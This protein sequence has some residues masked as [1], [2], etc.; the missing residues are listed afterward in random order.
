MR[1][2][3]EDDGSE[4]EDAEPTY[5]DRDPA[6]GDTED[7]G[8]DPGASARPET[9]DAPPPSQHAAA[10]AP[11][12]VVRPGERTPKPVLQVL[13]LGSGLILMGLGL[14]LAFVALR[15]RRG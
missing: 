10:T 6:D 9:T 8:V 14:G 1:P 12:S 7:S 3:R 4:S 13:P 2:G 5:T 11:Q 15:V